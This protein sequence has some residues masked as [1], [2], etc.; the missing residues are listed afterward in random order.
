MKSTHPAQS[1]RTFVIIY[2][3]YEFEFA[4]NKQPSSLKLSSEI[5]A[6]KGPECSKRITIFRA[7]TSCC[8]SWISYSIGL[9]I[10]LPIFDNTVEIAFASS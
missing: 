3:V 5:R 8:F 10:G 9:H 1:L 4:H 7:I 2:L 6:I